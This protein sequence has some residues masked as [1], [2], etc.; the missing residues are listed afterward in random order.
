MLKGTLDDFTLA[1]L[2]KLLSFSKKTGR[3]ELTRKAGMGRVFFRDGEV[4][5]AESSL[6]REPLGQKLIR[7]RALTDSHLR[8]ALDEHAETGERVGQILLREG[9]VDADELEAAVKAQIE[10]SVF[11]LL[12][13]D[14]GEFD[15]EPGV[16]LEPEVPISVSVENLIMESSRRLDELETISRKVPSSDAVIAV[17]PAP[18]EGAVEINITPDEW[19]VLVLVDGHRTVE[20]IA[21]TIGLDEF[22]TMR[23]VHGMVSAG[24]VEVT[25]EDHD[26]AGVAMP[27]PPPPVESF[28]P[29][30]PPAEEEVPETPADAQTS[31]EPSEAAAEAPVYEVEAQE[32]E[33]EEPAE[34]TEA[35]HASEPT[36]DEPLAVDDTTLDMSDFFSDS[37]ANEPFN[38]VEEEPFATPEMESPHAETVQAAAESASFLDGEDVMEETLFE[39]PQVQ[40][41]AQE[42]EEEAVEEEAPQTQDAGSPPEEWFNDPDLSMELFDRPSPGELVTERPATNGTAITHDEIRAPET[43][44][45]DEALIEM[46]LDEPAAP[47]MPPPPPAAPVAPVAPVAGHERTRAVRELSD[48]FEEVPVERPKRPVLRR[49]EP[50]DNTTKRRVEDDEQVTKSLI[51]RLIEG[52]K[53]L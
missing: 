45:S 26:Q 2:F 5:F 23:I 31:E 50:G 51:S 24:L 6:S 28:S 14:L 32:L 41:E 38:P 17:A 22:Q 48:L 49:I 46:P 43:Q 33:T 35:P 15:W 20:T 52:V 9:W 12:R 29:P 21:N 8:R 1:D 4:Y 44:P 7:S 27:P 18:P 36:S 47:S 11:D 10:D 13:W 30:A 40:A 37:G 3:L 34:E 42:A 53:G 19:R 39:A 16:T 25:G